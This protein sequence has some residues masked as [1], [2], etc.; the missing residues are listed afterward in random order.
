MRRTLRI[1]NASVCCLMLCTTAGLVWAQKQK[2]KPQLPVPIDLNGNWR[3]SEGD[4]ITIVHSKVG[5]KLGTKVFAK[6]SPCP[7]GGARAL[8]FSG[9]LQGDTLSGDYW[10]CTSDPKLIRDCCGGEDCWK[11]SFKVTVTNPENPYLQLGTVHNL[12][13]GTYVGQHWDYDTKDGRFI[14]CTHKD[15]TKSI[16]FTR[17]PTGPPP[18]SAVGQPPAEQTD[19]EKL[20]TLWHDTSFRDFFGKAATGRR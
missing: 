20:K 14:N 5:K 15:T 1:V 2:T 18:G 4:V 6:G 7:N 3:T 11:S 13:T 19:W 9:N 12:M 10:R 17:L 16:T 8:L